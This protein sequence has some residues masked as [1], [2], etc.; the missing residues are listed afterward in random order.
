MAKRYELI[1]ADDDKQVKTEWDTVEGALFNFTMAVCKDPTKTCEVHDLEKHI[2]IAV[3][4]HYGI[5]C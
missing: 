3:Y 5:D 4:C 1:V 2:T